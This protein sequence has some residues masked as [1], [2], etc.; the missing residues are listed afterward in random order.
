MSLD[1]AVKALMDTLAAAGRPRVWEVPPEE[2]RKNMLAL[3][4]LIDPKDVTRGAT[5]DGTLPGPAGAIPYRLYSPAGNAVVVLPALVYFHGGGF[6]LGNIAT[7]DVLCQM[8]ANESRC[9]IVSVDYRLAPEHKFPAG[10]EDC[11][12][13]TA[14]VAANAASLGI[15]PARLGVAGDSAG[16]N[17]AAA[18]CHLAKERGGPA[19]RLQLLLCPTLAGRDKTDSARAYAEG[20]FLEER[21]MQWFFE[22]YV[23]AGTDPADP[24]IAPLHAKDHAGL[25]RAIIHTA[26]FD[27][28]RDDGDLYA[29]ALA[30]A[31]VPVSYA[32]HPG[33]I[34]HFYGMGGVVPYGRKALAEIAA[35]AGDAL[36]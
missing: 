5:R 29:K 11:Y 33:M 15:D 17:L 23:D 7:H 31:G 32:C 35:A 20:Y 22:Q 2:T 8:L 13:A 9:R 28:L 18:V 27:P 12:A 16:A 1:P 3:S 24:R 34:H 25:P 14:W 6:V 36:A 26:E 10:L 30:K 4:Q 21:G 19:L